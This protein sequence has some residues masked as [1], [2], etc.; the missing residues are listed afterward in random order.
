MGVGGEE[1]EKRGAESGREEAEVRGVVEEIDA[2]QCRREQRTMDIDSRLYLDE[3]DILESVKSK[4]Y[5]IHLL[6]A[7]AHHPL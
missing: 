1:A 4:V 5:C 2:R 7:T 3:P 6:T